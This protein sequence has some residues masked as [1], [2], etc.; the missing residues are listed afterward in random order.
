MRKKI[1][2]FLAIGI[3]LIG[4]ITAS[5]VN[6]KRNVSNKDFSEE[7]EIGEINDSR[8]VDECTDEYEY[9]QD[10]DSIYTN[11]E[12]EKV[13]PNCKII[14]RTFYK[15]CGHVK[16]EEIKADEEMVNKTKDEI[17]EKFPE[18]EVEKFSPDEIVLY[19]DKDGEC[20]E[21][22]I[23]EDKEGKIVVY[24]IEENGDKIFYKDTNIY[25]VYLTQ[26]DR[27]GIENGIKVYGKQDL[28]N[29]LEDFEK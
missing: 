7:Y 16:K 27:I 13:S 29:I 8:V 11:S 18:Y 24:K 28:N 1:Y 10:K 19:S 12:V 25:T 14:F 6:R 21:H 20:G 26:T 17:K 15:G 22:Y 2:I 9:F 5:I 4:I 23:L 3:I